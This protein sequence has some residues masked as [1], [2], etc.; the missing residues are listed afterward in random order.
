MH[1]LVIIKQWKKYIWNKDV[2]I[3]TSNTKIEKNTDITKYI[4]KC[5]ANI[6]HRIY[7]H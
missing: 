6:I 2:H 4:H 7:K 1:K 3:I 5:K